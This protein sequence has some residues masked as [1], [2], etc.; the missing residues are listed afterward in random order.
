VNKP[1]DYGGK[2]FV[3]N[4]K[5]LKGIAVKLTAVSLTAMPF[6][7]LKFKNSYTT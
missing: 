6:R 7:A 2:K 3:K 5:A 4:F 1:S